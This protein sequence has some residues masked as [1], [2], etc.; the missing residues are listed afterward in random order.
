MTGSPTEQR[1]RAAAFELFEQQGYDATTVESIAERAG[2]GRT[3]FFRAFGSK[4]DVIFPDHTDVLARVRQR[5]AA[6]SA[7]ETP[8]AV[9]EAARLVLRRYLDEGDLARARYRLTRTIPALRSREIAHLQQYQQEFRDHIRR[10]TGEEPGAD[11]RAELMASSVVVAHNHVLRRWL[12]GLT[13]DPER[14]FDAAMAQV[15]RTHAPSAPTEIAGDDAGAGAGA[16]GTTVVVLRSPVDAD[17]VLPA[18]RRALA[19]AEGSEG[20]GPATGPV[21]TS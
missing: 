18:L 6:S 20:N 17:A 8:A 19:Q 1:L 12:R 5:L 16:R 3:T 2:V 7:A 15:L 4:E 14:E 10:W 9:T 13:E 11:L 21:L